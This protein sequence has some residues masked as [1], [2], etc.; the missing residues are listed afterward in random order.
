MG[1]HATPDGPEPR[2]SNRMHPYLTILLLSTTTAALTAQGPVV[3]PADRATFEG[4]SYTHLPLG[5]ASA[6]MQ[7]LHADVPGGTVITGHSYR[8]D[9]ALV[10][11]H[12]DPFLCDLQVTLSVTSRTP[13][14][15]SSTF[16]NNV[17]TNPVVVLPRTLVQFPG[18]DRPSLDPTPTFDFA[19]PYAVPF[20]M[21][22]GGG[23]LCVDI[24]VFGNSSPLGSNHN[25]SI[26]LDGHENYTDG[27]AE[28]P[29]YRFGQGCAAPGRTGIPYAT[30][31]LWHLGT[32][33]QFDVAH[34][35]GV[36]ED[37][38]GLSRVWLAM[39]TQV[40]ASPWPSNSACT[41]WG[42][43]DVWYA[44]PGS[45][46]ANG[47]YDGSLT[48]LPL[49]PQGVRLWC[50]TGSAHLGTGALAF[51]DGTTIVTPPPGPLPIPVSRVAN[52]N[53]HASA[54]GSVSYAV[55]VMA[56]F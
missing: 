11:G 31:T 18:S 24:E 48:N 15:A 23:T 13:Q 38:T 56:F 3:S 19:I 54:T 32:S 36:A 6:R 40:A 52:S 12:V 10:H 28:Q 47:A 53:D 21:P 4:S 22:A 7:T 55:P 46:D 51:G 33:M 41:L 1:L 34:R 42:S 25:L 35:N 29:G 17:G 16:A 50:Q 26:Y 43:T 44:L 39:G 9:A 20:S 27:R 2:A 14:Q 8:R 37:G 5:R 45:P 30:L 49:L